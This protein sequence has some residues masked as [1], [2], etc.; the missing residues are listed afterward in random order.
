MQETSIEYLN[1]QDM[2]SW[3]LITFKE[4]EWPEAI[5]FVLLGKNPCPYTIYRIYSTKRTVQV[6]L[7]LNKCII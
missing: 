1:S 6:V 5:A 2:K 7:F 3:L 4:G